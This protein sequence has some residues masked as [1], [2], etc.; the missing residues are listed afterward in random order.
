MTPVDIRFV[1]HSTVLLELPGI[2]ILTDPFLRDRLGPLR[3]HGPLPR[4]DDLGS[5]DLVLLSHAH[6]DHFDRA[7]LRALHGDPL[8]VAPR[9]LGDAIAGSGRRRQEVRVGD[10]IDVGGGWS[11]Q[12]VAARHWRWPAA[13][14]A[15]A[16]GYV[17]ERPG[18]AGVYFPGDTSRFAGMSAL[19]GRVDLALLPVGRWG[20]HVSPGHLSPRT[21]AEVARDVGARVA[22]PIH[23][24][25]LYPAALAGGERLTEPAA[26]FSRWAERLAPDVD[27]VALVPGEQTHID[28]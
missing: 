19:A 21:A 16:I 9:G 1:G 11:V 27:V 12:P 8:V 4:P 22:V 17:I 25:T 24:G 18:E 23:W 3:R 20:P 2:R 13:P 26:K 14:R 28:L 6:P 7:S 10:R 5:I 15:A